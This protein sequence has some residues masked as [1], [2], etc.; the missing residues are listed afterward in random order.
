[1]SWD[2]TDLLDGVVRSA[3]Y[4]EDYKRYMGLPEKEVKSETVGHI[5]TS[6]SGSLEI[7]NL[8]FT[9]AGNAQPTLRN[10][11]M[12]IESGK[13]Y[14]LVGTNG[15]GKS[16]LMKL[17]LGLYDDYDGEIF[18]DGRNINEFSQMEINSGIT[19]VFQDFAH[20]ALP[21]RDLINL[22]KEIPSS[23]A[24]IIKAAGDLALTGLI[25]RMEFDLGRS[26]G[27]LLKDGTD[28]SGGEWQRVSIL[29]AVMRQSKIVILDEPTSALDPILES[30]IYRDFAQACKDRT[31]LSISHRL[32]SIS[33]ADE[34]FVLADGEI[35]EQGTHQEL[36]HK[37][38]LY[39]RMYSLQKKW[40]ENKLA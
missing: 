39:Y 23:D 20:F 3:E 19:A 26:L 24:E 38:G 14:A 27:K 12:K 29:N 10:I 6:A 17:I 25:E 15:S 30:S 28:L 4:V 21:F 36:M 2:F 11:N 5:D 18:I 34:I 13:K 8:T 7:K 37:Q 32:G 33:D 35:A 22:G 31:L 16:T 1:M 9:Y 40:Y